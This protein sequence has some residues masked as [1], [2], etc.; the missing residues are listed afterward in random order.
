MSGPGLVQ[1]WKV[2]HCQTLISS[3]SAEESLLSCTLLSSN[4]QE[5]D[6]QIITVC[7]MRTVVEVCT[8]YFKSLEEQ[9]VMASGV[10]NILS[11]E[12]TLV[13]S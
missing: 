12:E 3:V 5:K 11:M 7:I 6:L 13:L 4:S 10:R 8:K 2:K 1:S 9:L